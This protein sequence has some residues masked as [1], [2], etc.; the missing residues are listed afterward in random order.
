MRVSPCCLAV[1]SKELLR[2]KL[3]KQLLREFVL[4][5]PSFGSNESSGV[6]KLP[7]VL[8]S[9]G[10]RVASCLVDRQDALS[11]HATGGCAGRLRLDTADGITPRCQGGID[12]SLKRSP[13]D[14]PS[15]QLQSL[16]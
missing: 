4:S 14:H 13:W 11:R 2:V 5:G 10:R 12:L 7:D 1:L 6:D 8:A 16:R 15:W 9:Q 3:L